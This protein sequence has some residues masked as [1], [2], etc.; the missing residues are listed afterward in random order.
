[1]SS[2]TFYTDRVSIME[3]RI[4]FALEPGV[5]I[6]AIFC[7]VMINALIAAVVYPYL[8]GDDAEETPDPS[9]EGEEVG[10]VEEP[11]EESLEE[12]IDQFHKEISDGQ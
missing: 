6:F 4:D 9:G 10:F 2:L 3:D 7:F 1:M 11:S 5:V 8:K 12:R